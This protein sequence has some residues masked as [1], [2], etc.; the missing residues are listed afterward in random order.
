[1]FSVKNLTRSGSSKADSSS[2]IVSNVSCRMK[3][4][5]FPSWYKYWHL[6]FVRSTTVSEWG[7]GSVPPLYSSTQRTFDVVR[8][9]KDLLGLVARF[10]VAHFH[11]GRAAS[12]PKLLLLHARPTVICARRIAVFTNDASTTTSSLPSTS[13]TLPRRTAL[14]LTLTSRTVQPLGTQNMAGRA[15]T[16]GTE[17]QGAT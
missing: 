8:G 16:W 11:L 13:I 12:E 3:K 6:T 2:S 15:R 10:H 14:A 9:A 17:C 4:Y 7:M 1:M 5:F